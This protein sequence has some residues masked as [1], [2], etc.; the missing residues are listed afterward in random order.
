VLNTTHTRYPDGFYNGGGGSIEIEVQD[1][2]GRPREGFAGQKR[3]R[4]NFLSPFPWK[5]ED[6]P[7]RWTGDRSLGLLA[8]ERI[9]LVFLLRDARL[10]SF[11]SSKA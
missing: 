5:G 3:A 8:G 9:R 1:E 7:A 10:Y 4:H 6:R 11:R 2:K